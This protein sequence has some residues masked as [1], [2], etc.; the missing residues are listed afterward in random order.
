MSSSASERGGFKEVI[1]KPLIQSKYNSVVERDNVNLHKRGL[2]IKVNKNFSKKLKTEPEI[3]NI[4]S[5]Y[6]VSQVLKEGNKTIQT[7]T[8]N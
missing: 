8:H 6:Y 7:I 2:S 1:F 4:R 5:K 3:E